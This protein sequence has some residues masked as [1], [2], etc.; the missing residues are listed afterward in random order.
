MNKA[1]LPTT[2]LTHYELPTPVEPGVY[3]SPTSVAHHYGAPADPYNPNLQIKGVHVNGPGTARDPETDLSTEDIR[4]QPIHYED[5][6][7]VGSG[8]YESH[9]SAA[10]RR[11]PRHSTETTWVT[12]YNRE[13]PFVEKTEPIEAHHV[14]PHVVIRGSIRN[15][16]PTGHGRVYY[17]GRHAHR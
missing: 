12:G 17:S 6:V 15:Q 9:N 7:S 16:S 1:P 8:V 2:A 13:L 10:A 3:G 14:E 5:P 4:L 11:Q